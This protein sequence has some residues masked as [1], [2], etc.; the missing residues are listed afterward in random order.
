MEKEPQRFIDVP[1]HPESELLAESFMQHNYAD[2][3]A[4]LFDRHTRKEALRMSAEIYGMLP[5]DHQNHFRLIRARP[6]C[7]VVRVLR[8]TVLSRSVISL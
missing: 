4:A 8:F 7:E 1:L 6:S 5:G 3:Y 2:V